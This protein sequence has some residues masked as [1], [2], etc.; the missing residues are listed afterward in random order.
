MEHQP[1]APGIGCSC[2][3]SHTLPCSSKTPTGCGAGVAS[4]HLNVSTL[5]TEPSKLPMISS[6][7]PERTALWSGSFPA[8][9]L[10]RRI[11]CSMSWGWRWPWLSDCPQV[12]LF[13]RGWGEGW[14]TTRCLQS[15]L[16]MGVPASSRGVSLPGPVN[17]LCLGSEW[18]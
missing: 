15:L 7:K 16:A 12:V 18:S 4:S 8:L 11:L 2:L 1:H 9:M 17:A 14:G 3:C 6:D 10:R 13:L 5:A